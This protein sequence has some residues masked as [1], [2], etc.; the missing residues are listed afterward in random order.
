MEAWLAGTPVL[1]HSGCAVT[2]GHVEAAGGG[3]HF[4]DY[5]HFAECLDLLLA[6]P[7]LR[8]RLAAAGREYVLANYSWPR[9]TERYLRLIERIERRAGRLRHA[10]VGRSGATPAPARRPGRPPDAAGFR[11][12]R[13]HRQRGPGPAKGVQVVGRALGDLCRPRAGAAARPGSP[14][15]GVRPPG[16]SGRRADLPLLDRPPAGRRA[17]RAARAQGSALSQHHSGPLP[18]G[19]LSRRGR[20]LPPGTATA[21]RGWPARWN[22][23]WV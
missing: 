22:S 17:A 21:R 1:V 8:R 6:R 23:G 2:R 7:D 20:A 16:R 15:R 5:P 14:R 10:R 12:R 4:A 18:R 3:L 9:V 19:R 13:C 11:R